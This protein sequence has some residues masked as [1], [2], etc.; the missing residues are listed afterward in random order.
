MTSTSRNTYTLE[1]KIAPYRWEHVCHARYLS[2]L[3][4][5]ARSL[6][7]AGEAWRIVYAPL[8]RIFTPDIDEAFWIEWEVVR[9][10]IRRCSYDSYQRSKRKSNHA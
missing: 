3:H 7:K 5:R 1:R 4:D 10:S 8:L 2:D 6:H 9:E